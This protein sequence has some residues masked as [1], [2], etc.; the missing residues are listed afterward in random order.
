MK[1]DNTP[2]VN[3]RTRTPS[4]KLRIRLE[5][6]KA[7]KLKT[8]RAKSVRQK[9]KEAK[10]NA[11]QTDPENHVSIS[12]APPI[13]KNKLMDPPT[14]TSKY[15]RRQVEKTWLPTHIWHTKRAHMTRPTEPL[16]RMAIPLAPTEKSYRPSHR[17]A[18]A[19][20]CIAWDMSYMSTISCRGTE[21]S[22]ESMLKALKFGGE[23]WSG[24]KYE[25]WKKGTRFAEGWVYERDNE[26]RIIAPVTA[27][28]CVETTASK[29]IL[30][31]TANAQAE[32][33]MHDETQQLA[34]VKRRLNRSLLLRVHPSAFLHL[35]HELIKVAKM[36]KPQVLLEDLRF[37][38]GSIEITGPASTETLL[39]VLKPYDSSFSSAST[40]H[41]W[42]SLAG[43]MNPATL[44]Y[45]TL[46]AF[47]I[48]DPRLRH[49]PKQMQ[50][51]QDGDLAST[52]DELVVSWPLDSSPEPGGIFSRKC[53]WQASQLPSQHAINRRKSSL[54]PGQALDVTT[55]DPRIPVLLFASRSSAGGN[56]QGT[57][58]VLMPWRCVDAVWRS[59]MYYPQSSGGIP[60]FGG[61]NQKQQIVF[62]QK[63][64]WFPGDMPGTEAGK[65]WQRTQDEKKFDEWVRRPTSRRLAYDMV[66]LG[67]GRKGELGRGWACD[68][69]F[70]FGADQQG[71]CKPEETK[72]SQEPAP[73][74]PETALLTQRQRKAARTEAKP[75]SKEQGNQD[76]KRRNT[77]SPESDDG[78]SSVG[79][80]TPSIQSSPYVHLPPESALAL[81]KQ[82][83]PY[84]PPGTP[85]LVT[86]RITLLSRGTPDPTARIYQLPSL[87]FSSVD[88]QE[89]ILPQ[90]DPNF[91]T[92][93]SA[94]SSSSLPTPPP[95]AQP[96]P[97]TSSSTSLPAPPSPSNLRA[98]WLALDPEPIRTPFTIPSHKIKPNRHG[99]PRKQTHHA[100][101]SLDHINVLPKNAPPE[102]IKQYGP[103][104]QPTP[105]SAA[106]VAAL[107]RERLIAELLDPHT[108]DEQGNKHP[109]CPDAGDL[110][111]FVTSGN[112]N[113]AE[114][115]GT[116]IASLWLQ[117]VV[118]GWKR[119][120]GET[121]RAPK[122]S[123]KEGKKK[124]R[125][126]HLC[127]VRN[128]GETVGRLG[129]WEV[130]Q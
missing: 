11:Q 88:R 129:V 66:D 125:E 100:L 28:W 69:E 120:D 22:L 97:A 116:A 23:G 15:K 110:I 54:P 123:A 7:I 115:K 78:N 122:T 130:C 96:P 18:G 106:E 74:P 21:A 5:T 32:V 51:L 108:K 9:K 89:S 65:A 126:R 91:S 31:R 35:W 36:Q 121:V 75:K 50:R 52:L 81:L 19:R 27:I 107:E 80:I 42:M 124:D 20:G 29:T 73:S 30:P 86:V 16:W 79:A 6:A 1:E 64:P 84:S 8:Q 25:R 4:R 56:V 77:S 58:T 105:P 82:A 59:V 12:R 98:Q 128:S 49:P 112:Y 92:R 101:E 43:L 90:S 103:K 61:L 127:I 104:P 94:A 10:A 111:G 40:E 114:G 76:R 38:I 3:S 45:N 41:V 57:W 99:V 62:E 17:A 68:W 95:A 72:T 70:L 55:K 60:R 109:P 26:R 14:A 102:V 39:G 113:L 85:A 93:P 67:L 44:P 24:A 117:R 47:D 71:T 34:K 83:K 2:T 46:L 13:K 63:T 119:E 48:S 118:E 37:E 33:E 87:P 53:R